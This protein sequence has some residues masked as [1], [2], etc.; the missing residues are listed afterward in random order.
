MLE[1]KP[2]NSHDSAYTGMCC[3]YK[4]GPSCGPD[5]DR[6]ALMWFDSETEDLVISGYSFKSEDPEDEYYDGTDSPAVMVMVGGAAFCWLK[7]VK[8][9]DEADEVARNLNPEAFRD[10]EWMKKMGFVD[11]MN[12]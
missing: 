2:T 10:V 5:M 4:D 9:A 12:P 7:G 3:Y 8:T 6:A 11:L 1:L